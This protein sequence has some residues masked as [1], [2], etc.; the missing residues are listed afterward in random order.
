MC[1]FVVLC[2]DELLVGLDWSMRAEVTA[3]FDDLKRDRAVVVVS[4]DVEEI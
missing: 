1:D 4:Y 3:L 2:L